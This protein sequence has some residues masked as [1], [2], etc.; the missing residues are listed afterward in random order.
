MKIFHGFKTAILGPNKERYLSLAFDFCYLDNLDGMV[1]NAGFIIFSYLNISL[2][3][4][5]DFIYYAF[6]NNTNYILV[7]LMENSKLENNIFGYIFSSVFI[8][9]DEYTG[10][11]FTLVNSGEP[12]DI[13][14]DPDD[15]LLK[16]VLEDGYSF[17]KTL[18]NFFFQMAMFPSDNITEI[19]EYCDKINDD[20]GDKNDKNSIP[21]SMKESLY[22]DF[23]ILITE[24]LETVCNDTNC[25]LCLG[26]DINYFIV[27]RGNYSFAMKP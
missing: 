9:F 19:N 22:T 8:F 1:S 20:Y 17:E 13:I 16:I 6:N 3:K 2:E 14:L 11:N 24:N 18:I 15:N 27:C 23:N 26:K 21:F 7:D 5:F 4:N 12:L 25:I 10:I